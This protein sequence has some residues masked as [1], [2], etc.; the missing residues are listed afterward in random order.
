M[1]IFARIPTRHYMFS[2]TVNAHVEKLPDS[3][4]KHNNLRATF[5][6]QRKVCK[7]WLKN[8]REYKPLS[9]FLR[10]PHIPLQKT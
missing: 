3:K 2:F 4:Q 7:R 1:Y 5:F 6:F 10:I 8:G 9:S